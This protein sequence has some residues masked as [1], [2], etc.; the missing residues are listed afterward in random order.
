[1][2]AVKP[3]KNY[4]F[5]QVFYLQNYLLLAACL[6]T[7]KG[8]FDKSQSLFI[9]GWG[10]VSFTKMHKLRNLYESYQILLQTNTTTRE[11]ATWLQKAEI[12]EVPL[13]ECNEIYAGINLQQLPENLLPS[14]LCATS[15]TKEGKILDGCQGEFR[16]SHL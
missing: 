12:F 10:L 13:T 2:K 8:S 3:G 15:T 1:M 16:D 9:T 11:K 14:Q 7:M 6:S 4:R 5:N